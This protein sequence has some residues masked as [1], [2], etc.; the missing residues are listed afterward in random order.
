MQ[1]PDPMTRVILEII[2]LLTV[3]V[4]RWPGKRR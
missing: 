4:S 3:L 2:R 1:P